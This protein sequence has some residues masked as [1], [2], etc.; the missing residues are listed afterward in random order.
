MLPLAWPTQGDSKEQ[1]L[2]VPLLQ[3]THGLAVPTEREELLQLLPE[4]VVVAAMLLPLL[5]FFAAAAAAA[6]A[7]SRV[8][9]D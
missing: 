4:A 6:T 1:Q 9:I 5:D 3:E 8:Y 7:T 2:L